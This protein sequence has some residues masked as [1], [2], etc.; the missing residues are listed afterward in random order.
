MTFAPRTHKPR[1]RYLHRFHGVLDA[2]QQL[3][4]RA[5]AMVAAVVDGQHW[6]GLSQ[7]VTLADADAEFLGPQSLGFLTQK[8]SAPIT[9]SRT[10]KKS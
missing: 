2:G 10:L 5:V 3:A 4:D 7:T 9:T 6:A 8:A 1:R